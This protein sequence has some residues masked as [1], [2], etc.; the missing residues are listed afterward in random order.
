MATYFTGPNASDYLGYVEAENRRRAAQ[1]ATTNQLISDIARTAVARDRANNELT[2][3]QGALSN[4]RYGMDNRSAMLDRELANRTAMSNSANELARYQHAT[5]SGSVMEQG[6]TATQLAHERAMF[7][8]EMATNQLA[9][10]YQQM[11]QRGDEF[12]QGLEANTSMSLLPFTVN[13]PVDR[14]TA[15]LI[16]EQGASLSALAKEANDS[17]DKV[18]AKNFAW[19]GL[20]DPVTSADRVRDARVAG[21]DQ[22]YAALGLSLDP[23]TGYFVPPRQN[24]VARPAVPGLF[25]QL[26]GRMGVSLPVQGASVPAPAGRD[27]GNGIK[28]FGPEEPYRKP[29]GFVP[30]QDNPVAAPQSS[31]FPGQLNVGQQAF[32]NSL[33]LAQRNEL[34]SVLQDPALRRAAGL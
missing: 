7:D 18:S 15:A 6:K 33:P 19:S 26:L 5:P 8:R 14:D 10:A 20:R 30:V 22:K 28:R 4:D 29:S 31:V 12:K 1:A 23:A 34:L 9:L 3:G 27:I 13:Q 24:Y 25:N 16:A 17:V 2:L 11:G 32:I 21:L